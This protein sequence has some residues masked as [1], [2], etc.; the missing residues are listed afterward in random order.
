MAKALRRHHA[1]SELTVA[2]TARRTRLP[3][4]HARNLRQGR[5]QRSL[6]PGALKPGNDAGLR[7]GKA[8]GGR[9]GAEVERPVGGQVG[10]RPQVRRHD[11][12]GEGAPKAALDVSLGRA[13]GRRGSRTGRQGGH[14]GGGVGTALGV[15]G[16][17][18]GLR[19]GDDVRDFA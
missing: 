14:S 7:V 1:F 17:L 11:D 15:M 4:R 10:E 8:D 19:M 5:D 3:K 16:K 13:S 9:L 6:G 18:A 12:A 2:S